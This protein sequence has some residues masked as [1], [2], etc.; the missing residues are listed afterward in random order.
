MQSLIDDPEVR[1]LSQRFS[2]RNVDKKRSSAGVPSPQQFKRRAREGGT[3]EFMGLKARAARDI[4]S[5]DIILREALIPLMNSAGSA[6]IAREGQD[7]DRRHLRAL[8][9]AVHTCIHPRAGMRKR[10]RGTETHLYCFDI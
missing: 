4:R 2:L 10:A 5:G 3:N 6:L 9:L 8:D 7:R 1:H